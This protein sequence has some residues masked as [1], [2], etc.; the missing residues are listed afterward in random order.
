M[1]I[2]RRVPELNLDRRPIPGKYKTVEEDVELVHKGKRGVVV[3]LSN[4]DVIY[5]KNRD[6]VEE[7]A[8]A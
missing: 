6:I 1:R 8:S 2:R 4:G 5:R 3:K 7:E